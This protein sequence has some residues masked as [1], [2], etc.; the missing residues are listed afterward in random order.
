MN[1]CINPECKSREN[2][3]SLQF[4]Q[5]CETPL[6]LQGRY[7]LLKPL[8]TLD[9]R[10]STDIFEID[11]QGNS[12]VMKVLKYDDPELVDLF[13][14]EASILRELDHPGIPKVERG[15]FFKIKP[16]GSSRRIY[17]LVMEKIAGENLE[18]WLINHAP[19]SENLALKWLRQ[20]CEILDILH[21]KRFFH[22]DIKPA[23]II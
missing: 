16:T 10:Y 20:I 7:R 21:K 17:C 4:C 12:K 1:Y 11:D 9:P 5:S 14:R 23:N 13:F 15:G 6:L 22:R 8:R 19:I 18:T 2:P 3:K